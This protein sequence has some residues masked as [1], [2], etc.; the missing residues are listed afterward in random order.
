MPKKALVLLLLIFAL[1]LALRFYY[2]YPDRIIFGFDQVIDT[3]IAR[4]IV[5]YRDLTVHG[6]FGS[7]SDINHG[8]LFSYFTAIA[9]FIGRGSPVFIAYWY[10]FFNA[11]S[12]VVVF[13]FAYLVFRDLTLS[14]TASFLAAASYHLVLMGGWISN[15]TLALS[16]AP[17]LFIFTWLYKNGRGWALPVMSFVLGLLI[18]SQV[19]MIYN[20]VALFILWYYFKLKLPSLKNFV[21]SVL[22]FSIAVLTMIVVEIKSGFPDLG[23]FLRPGSFLDEA[24]APLWQRF[25]LFGR[26]FLESFSLSLSPFYASFGMVAGVVIV[27]FIL[28]GLILTRRAKLEKDRLFFLSVFLFA[29]AVMLL[30]GFHDK[31]W[32]LMGMIPAVFISTS[33]VISR[34]GPKFLRFA[35][36]SL[37][38][39]LN[40]S[41]IITSRRNNALFIPQEESSTLKGQL[42]VIDYTYH[43]AAGKSFAVNSVTYPLY[44]NTYWSYH[45][46]AYGKKTYGYLPAWLGGDQIYPFDSLPKSNAKEKIFFMIIDD[47]AAIPEVH[48]IIGRNWGYAFGDLAEEKEIGGFT[49]QKFLRKN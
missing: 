10:A 21:L 29:P 37:I 34:I 25:F 4:K 15:T 2:I 13:V 40:V 20:V 11:L 26:R 28:V 48:K 23:I 27:L 3:I 43:E 5:D 9:Y 7:T 6:L 46:P 8:V 42:E 19:L 18:E 1:G 30:I 31:P 45:Y 17:L 39:F 36:L 33:Y 35:I 47:T 16:L 22:S 32:S 41:A 44:Y 38:L 12:V 24:K 14:L 49:V